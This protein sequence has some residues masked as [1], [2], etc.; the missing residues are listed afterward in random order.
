MDF[1][2][3]ILTIGIPGSGKSTWVKEYQKQHSNGVFVISTDEIRKEITGIEQCVDPSQNTRIHEEAR[4][5]AKAI[6][7]DRKNLSKKYG[8]WPVIIIDSTNVDVEEW[9]AYKQ[10]GAHIMMA[11]IFD[12]TP[13]EALKRMENRERKV[14]REILEWKW[15]TLE[16][17]RKDIPKFF[18]L[19]IY[20]I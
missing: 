11:K 13:D 4:K 6:I 2:V 19:I 16:K 15:D 8:T 9:A 14:P 20:F 18:N 3:L 10:L 5:R 7:D 17:N 1:S 12:V